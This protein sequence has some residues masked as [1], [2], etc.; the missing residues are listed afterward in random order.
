MD[1]LLKA[2]S[3]ANEAHR[4][5]KRKINLSPYI[6]HPIAVGMILQE[7]RAGEDCI[8]AGV[9][10]D[11]LEDTPVTPLQIE[12]Q[13][14]SKILSLVI[15]VS[16]NKSIDDWFERKRLYIQAKENCSLETKLICASDKFHNL[17]TIKEDYLLLGDSI[18]SKFKRGKKDQE[19]FYRSVYNSLCKGIDTEKYFVFAKMNSLI[20]TMF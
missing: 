19:W 8:V 18:W 14:G 15:S 10:H 7:M 3:F 20:E 16:E 4:D 13:F 5:Q 2:I 9:L 17:F 11:V 1:Q 6:M 12:E